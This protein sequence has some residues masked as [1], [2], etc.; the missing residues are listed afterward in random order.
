LDLS[1]A[2]LQI[3]GPHYIEE[4]DVDFTDQGDNKLIMGMKNKA[5]GF[6]TMPGEG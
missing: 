4:L 1:V 6:D 3:L 2:E 5:T